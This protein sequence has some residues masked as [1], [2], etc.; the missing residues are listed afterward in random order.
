MSE[1]DWKIEPA[2]SS[3]WRRIVGV[4][5]VAV[6]ADGDR[7]AVAL[8]EVRLRVR[9]HGVAR[10]RVAHVA[11]GPVPGKRVEPRLREHVVHQP[12]ALLEPDRLPVARR[13]A[14][15]LLAAVLQGVEPHVGE[16]RGL[17]VA[18]DAEEAALVVEVVVLEGQAAQGR[19]PGLRSAHPAD[20]SILAET[21]MGDPAFPDLRAFLDQL[22][23]DS[24][25][26]RR[27][28]RGGS[29]SRG[30]RD[31]PPRRSR[32]AAPRCSSRRCA[33]RTFPL[34]TNL[35]GT[36]RRARL[37]FG[38]RPERLVKRLVHLAETLVPPTPAQAV[39]RAGRRA[40]GAAHRPREAAERAGHGGRD[41]RRAPR[42]PAR[43]HLLAG[44]RRPLRHAAPRLHGAPRRARAR[45]NLGMYRLHVHD[46]RTT[47]MHWQIGKGGGFHHARGGGA[48]ASRCRSPSSS[49][50]R[51]PS[52][53]AAIAPLP[54]NVPELM[55]ASLIAGRRLERCA[56]PGAHP[57]VASAE[58][59]LV[60]HVPA[61]VRRPE[62]P[63]GD[64][65]GYY[66][67]RHD[68]PVFRVDALCRRRDAIYPATVVGK[69]RQEDFFI[70]DLPAGAARAAL[71]ARHARRRATSGP[72]ARRA[73]TRSPPRSSRSATSARRWPRPSASSARGSSRSPSSCWSWTDQPW[74]CATSGPRSSTSSRAPAPRRTSTSSRTSRW[75]RSTTRGPTVNEGSKGV[76]L[77]LGD[78]VRELPREF[79]PADAS[80]ARGDRRARV[81]RRL[82][83][84]R[85]PAGGRR[86]PERG[87]RLAAHPAFAGWPLLVLTDEPARAAASP[88]NFLWTTF[89]RF[90]PA[91]DV[92]ARPRRAS[93]ATTW[94]TSRRC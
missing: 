56:G 77:G 46:P 53:L 74:T 2:A 16:V 36:A 35:F 34:A 90:E 25:P 26:R 88:M 66:S 81:L 41:P 75:T 83:R 85:R 73:T 10:G 51:R 39:G 22:R 17:G 57:L 13:D 52:I 43:P 29:P 49:A 8:D 18:E 15:R 86:T 70:G 31:P 32:P 6:V 28:G 76:W 79:R 55:L 11:D 14:R 61:G 87:P 92:H 20:V 64:H 47:G 38:T 21:S 37:A 30:G 24:R 82:P 72:T 93:C 80:A 1:V 42:P 84:R 67:L 60:G 50:A 27:R 19:P 23:R 71:P 59:A 63:F 69:P 78:P 44:G 3:S 4:H 48:R 7:A 58:I 5:E 91:A 45:S 68:Y 9:G 33:A 89:T 65:Y 62:G 94:S 12:H 54:E 40:R